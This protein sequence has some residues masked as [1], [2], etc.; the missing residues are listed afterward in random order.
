MYSAFSFHVQCK[1]WFLRW[2]KGC[3][4]YN[5]KVHT[6]ILNTRQLALFILFYF[7]SNVFYIDWL[8][9][10]FACFLLSKSKREFS[11]NSQYSYQPSFL[12]NFLK[13]CKASWVLAMDTFPPQIKTFIFY[14]Q[15]FVRINVKT[16]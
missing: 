5:K 10:W 6:Y 16:K 7:Y 13:W 4:V 2:S 14:L 1:A 12:K 15:L 9:D 8:I 11:F 3:Y